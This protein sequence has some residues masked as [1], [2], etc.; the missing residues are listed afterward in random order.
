MN[1]KQ[2]I[3]QFMHICLNNKEIVLSWRISNIHV[4]ESLLSFDVFGFNYQ[5]PILIKI[6]GSDFNLYANDTYI[7]SASTPVEALSILDE[8]IEKNIN[9]YNLLFEILNI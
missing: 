2:E 6:I 3:I 7:G 8:Y 1:T 9:A 5:G 4:S